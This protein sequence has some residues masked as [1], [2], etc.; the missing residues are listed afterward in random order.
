MEK[1]IVSKT[2]IKALQNGKQLL[3]ESDLNQVANQ[4]ESLAN[5][6]VILIDGSGNYLANAYLST[7]NKGVGWVYSTRSESFDLALLI[8]R[9][10]EA[11]A[12]RQD[13]FTNEATT[14]FC[15]FNEEGDKLGGIRVEL[16]QQFAVFSWYNTFVYEHRL[17]IINAFRQVFPEIIGGYGKN[18]FKACS[19]ESEHLF[20]QAEENPVV[21]KENGINYAT[22]LNDGLMTGIFLDQREVRARLA[23]G[24]ARGK[25]L[26]NLFSYTAAFS[27]AAASGGASQ[28][29]SVDLAK[30]SIDK[31]LAHFALN[32]LDMTNHRLVVMDT[33]EYFKYAKRK[34]LRYDVIV[35]D[36]PSFAR[37]KGKVF[38]VHKNYGDLIAGA[39][40]ILNDNGI[41][42]ASTN[43]QNLTITAFE[44]I[45]RGALSDVD[46][47]F[48][49]T[50]RLPRDFR[51]N[52]KNPES[53][54][55]K[56]FV[57][58]VKK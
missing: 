45:L 12:L 10:K 11:R 22:S 23:A 2:T 49:S 27:V 29:T 40:N 37:N 14:A 20:G 6:A 15:L 51:Y 42:I 33:F 25:S 8:E 58:E 31:S 56:V 54:Y 32:G 41:I 36:P 13:F 44:K 21:I 50:F 46:Y 38:S 19:I 39:L 4:L 48:K 30:R 24:L 5:Q 28:T 57:I 16:Y 55:L 1:I 52:V 18:R 53:N 35:I 3:V 47:R 9:F 17:M 7:Q 26:L 34:S 43:A